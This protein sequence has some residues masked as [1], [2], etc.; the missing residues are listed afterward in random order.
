MKI[1]YP[2]R[3]AN[4][5]LDFYNHKVTFYPNGTL[6]LRQYKKAI[7]VNRYSADEKADRRD[8]EMARRADKQL[9]RYNLLKDFPFEIGENE[10]LYELSQDEELKDF[11]PPVVSEKEILQRKQKSEYNSFRR[12]VEK[13]NSYCRCVNWEWFCTFT[14]DDNKIDR[15]NFDECS[16]KLRKWFNNIRSNCSSDIQ[17]LVVPEQHESGAYHFHALLSNIDFKRMGFV[18]AKNN[19]E[20]NEDGTFNVYYGYDLIRKGRHVYN[21]SSFNLGFTDCEKIDDTRKVSNYILKYITKDMCRNTFS[22]RRYFVSRN[23]PKPEIQYHLLNDICSEEA[24]NDL[25]E[26]YDLTYEHISVIDEA[27]YQNVVSYFDFSLKRG[28]SNEH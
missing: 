19:K 22:K 5:N 8:R 26:R 6:N 12:T 7:C 1:K 15:F 21:I 27:D 20:F 18:H 28:V 2:K 10:E 3:Y 13:I 9:K 23:I 16:K 11:V 25:L 4:P 14:F 17:Y 24:F